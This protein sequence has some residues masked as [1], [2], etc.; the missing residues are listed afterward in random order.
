MTI[1]TTRVEA[2]SPSAEQLVEL[3]VEHDIAIRLVELLEL[4]P[5]YGPRQIGAAI[6]SALLTPGSTA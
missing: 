1:P 3:V 2:Y 6:R 4:Q 5:D